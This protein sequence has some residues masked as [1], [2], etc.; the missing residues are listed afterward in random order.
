MKKNTQATVL[1][2]LLLGLAAVL[3]DL[4]WM[5]RYSDTVAFLSKRAGVEW[6]LYPSLPQTGTRKPIPVEATFEYNFTLD[7]PPAGAVLSI[8][9]FRSF[10]LSVNGQGAAIAQP[11]SWKLISTQDIAGL[12]HQGSNNI[13]V[14]VTNSLGPPALW[15]HLQAGSLSMGT[16]TGWKVSQGGAE[17][18][19]AIPAAQP[20]APTSASTF[21][22]GEKTGDSIARVWPVLLLFLAISLGAVLLANRRLKRISSPVQWERL[23]YGLLAVV[24]IARIALWIHDAPQLRRNTGFDAPAHEQYVKFIQDKHALPKAAD[25]WEMYQPPLYYAIGAGLLGAFGLETGNDQSTHLLRAINGVVGTVHCLMALLCLR[26]LFPQK[27]GVQ[28]MGLLVYAFLPPNLY[29]SL[30]VTNEPLAGLFVTSALYFFLRINREDKQSA[31]LYVALGTA[32][33]AAVLTKA[34][35]LILLPVVMGILGLQSYARRKS[36]VSWLW[37]PGLMVV[38]C[39]AV[40]GWYYG[41][42]WVETGKLV[43][44]NWDTNSRY[45]F[46][47]YPGFRTAGYYYGF[48]HS[49]A[50]PL[51]SSY[52]SF[53][54]GLYST[55]W[56]DG[57]MSGA[58]SVV[59]R[60]PWNYD[61]MGS[62]YLLSMAIFLI[63][64]CGI[65]IVVFNFIQRPTFERA[66][67]LGILFLFS[68]AIVFMSLRVPF[69]SEM[70]A[71]YAFPAMFPLVILIAAG[72]DWLQTR[73]SGWGTAFWVVLL[74]WVMTVYTSYWV[75][76]SNP[77]TYFARGYGQLAEQDYDLSM[78]NFSKGA[79]LEESLPHSPND[80]NFSLTDG[81]VHFY[82]GYIDEH[83]GEA[84][85]AVK[86]Y[87]KA[88]ETNGNSLETLNDLS[89]LLATSA[90]PSI[91]NGPRAVELAERACELTHYEEAI[92]I[93][94]L[95]S[96]YAE[97]G[98]FDDAVA[99]A[100]RTIAMA[101]QNGEESLAE[102]NQ[103]LVEL[104]RAHQPYHEAPRGP[105]AK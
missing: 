3:G 83:N 17:W 71:F 18:Q 40:C 104:Y 51:F 45:L 22:G 62:G 9:A 16:D 27:I 66:V 81:A 64:L 86:E 88:L 30:Y 26:L 25:G 73:F 74:V 58:N 55:L 97:D 44:G 91:R 6:I 20:P 67:I 57:L 46:W 24:M 65:V 41:A 28:A 90:D 48:G 49:L 72:W 56:G 14:C 4:Y 38:S 100:L 10:V 101:Q 77:Q 54:D 98:R 33:G 84:G 39:L 89:R 31:S 11:K 7:E 36:P 1:L 78:Q 53:G 94:T 29:L 69:Y 43:L 12:L 21:F 47:Q 70:K 68:V 35:S 79:Q 96:A 105:A 99:A 102:N 52:W 95:A 82:E 15:L 23:I 2:V 37:M 92:F 50:S 8:C 5:C 80:Q 42:I 85:A 103:E 13:T 34:S 19:D 75:R 32:L 63:L 93:G 76:S 87:N 61:L 60:P 59:Y